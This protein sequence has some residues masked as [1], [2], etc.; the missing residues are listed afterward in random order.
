MF[1]PRRPHGAG[2]CP[3]LAGDCVAWCAWHEC[4]G[5]E[6]GGPSVKRAYQVHAVVGRGAECSQGS[7]WSRTSSA[8]CLLV[9]TA[10]S[11]IGPDL[12]QKYSCFVPWSGAAYQRTTL[13]KELIVYKCTSRSGLSVFHFVVRS[14]FVYSA[15]QTAQNCCGSRPHAV[16]VV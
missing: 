1:F 12:F 5:K 8:D 3:S 7:S 16:N 13:S 11:R 14:E 4:V 9:F 10:V 15:A 6:E 2:L